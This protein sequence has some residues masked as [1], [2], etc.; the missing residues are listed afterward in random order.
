M[1]LRSKFLNALM[2][3][4]RLN[5]RCA[6]APIWDTRSL[7]YFRIF[8]LAVAWFVNRVTSKFWE[9]IRQVLA[10]RTISNRQ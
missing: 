4:A 9:P 1:D 6:V 7:K 5:H 8:F 3:T 10:L 2:T